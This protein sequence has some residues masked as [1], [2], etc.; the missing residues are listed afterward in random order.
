[1]KMPLK[2]RFIAWRR[3]IPWHNWFFA[4]YYLFFGLSGWGA[5]SYTPSSIEGAAGTGL[6]YAWA[7]ASVLV[8]VLGIW[9]ALKPNFR[10][11]NWACYFG[12]ASTFIYSSTLI[13]II[14]GNQPTRSAQAF[15]IMRAIFPLM[16]RIVYNHL[17]EQQ[18][19]AE[20]SK[21]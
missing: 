6:T 8:G 7:T 18:V 10:F 2:H 9:G 1:M 20:L 13:I 11:E 3:R 12:I 21:A 15:A 5:L 4:G 17:R 16:M 14:L 19:A